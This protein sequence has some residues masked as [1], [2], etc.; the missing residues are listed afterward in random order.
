MPLWFLFAA[1]LLLL[2][3]L[4]GGRCDALRKEEA[5]K[6]AQG[7][8]IRERCNATHT[9]T[10][11]HL[12]AEAGSRVLPDPGNVDGAL[13]LVR[14]QGMRMIRVGEGLDKVGVSLVGG[15]RSTGAG[16]CAPLRVMDFREPVA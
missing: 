11:T 5:E 14:A 6:E 9:H 4:R 13:D 2:L 10:R 8:R 7:T 15:T 12:G 3:D 1:L 16:D